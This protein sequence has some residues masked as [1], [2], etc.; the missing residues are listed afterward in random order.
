MFPSTR[1][2]RLPYGLFSV[3]GWLLANG[4]SIKDAELRFHMQGRRVTSMAL[5]PPCRMHNRQS[6]ADNTLHSS[7]GWCGVFRASYGFKN[8]SQSD[9]NLH[10]YTV[11]T[12][13]YTTLGSPSRISETLIAT[14]YIKKSK[15]SLNPRSRVR[16]LSL[17][18]L[19]LRQQRN[20]PFHVRV[21]TYLLQPSCL[22]WC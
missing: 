17:G 10:G 18:S 19:P 15:C 5:F 8:A 21:H 14:V 11:P 7:S 6:T 12:Y 20:V 2:Q 22:S 9:V 13:G 1:P 4:V 3:R 16:L